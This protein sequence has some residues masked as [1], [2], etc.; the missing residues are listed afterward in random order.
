[1][2][3]DFL[4][5]IAQLNDIDGVFNGLGGSGPIR[6]LK[7]YESIGAKFTVT[8]GWSLLD[9][10]LL[11]SLG[12]EALGVYTAHWYA[13]SYDSPSNKRFV[14]TMQDDNHDRPGGGAAGMYIA[15]QVIDAA[16]RKTA[17]AIDDKS[18]FMDAIRAVDLTDTPRGHFRFDK[19]GNAVGP[20]FIRKCERRDGKLVNVV[21]KTYPDVSQFWTYDPGEFLSK[22]AYSRDYP[23][24]KA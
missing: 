15:G 21:V 19:Y 12:D 13:T 18:A 24:L 11:K 7:T 2:T 20:V 5:Y 17:G 8:G 10:P 22:P 23:P 4:P 9:E 3:P 1:V 6:F 16:L 14:A